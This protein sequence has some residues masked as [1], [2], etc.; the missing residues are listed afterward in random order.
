MMTTT[1]FL[2]LQRSLGLC[3]VPGVLDPFWEGQ[4]VPCNGNAW[5]DGCKGSPSAAG[6]GK[7]ERLI[8]RVPLVELKYNL[9]RTGAV[10]IITKVMCPFARL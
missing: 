6:V 8:E 3:A 1:P 5:M 2:A 10:P 4:D 9:L 7:R